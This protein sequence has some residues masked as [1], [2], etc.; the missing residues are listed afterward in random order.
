M[1]ERLVWLIACISV[2]FGLCYWYKQD[3]VNV[4]TL[5]SNL[6]THKSILIK[7]TDIARVLPT[8][9]QVE[10]A[11]AL[12]LCDIDESDCDVRAVD[13]FHGLR[14]AHPLEALK[15]RQ[16]MTVGQDASSGLVIDQPSV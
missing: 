11:G 1:P 6:T 15:L 7:M 9:D 10:F 5:E 3:S 4:F 14:V 2:D 12:S 8:D 13:R 16:G